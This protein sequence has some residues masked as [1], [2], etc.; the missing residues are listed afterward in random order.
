MPMMSLAPEA[1]T[2]TPHRVLAQAGAVAAIV[3]GSA[4][5]IAGFWTQ[6]R[7][8]RAITDPSDLRIVLPFAVAALAAG[9]VSL[10]RRERARPLAIAG[11]AMAAAAP[12]L[13]WVV[14]VAAVAVVAV[15]VALVVAKFS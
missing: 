2:G 13:G 5:L 11:M 8:E 15:V 9:V 7:G 14:L 3:L 10:V 6:F 1:S 4:A 12:L